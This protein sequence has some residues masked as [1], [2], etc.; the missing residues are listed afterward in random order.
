MSKDETSDHEKNID[1]WLDQNGATPMSEELAQFLANESKDESEEALKQRIHTA[2]YIAHQADVMNDDEV[3][4]WNRG[5]AFEQDKKP[6]WQWQGLPVLSTGFSIFALLLVVFNVEFVVQ[7]EGVLLSFGG[8]S[9]AQ[10]EAKVAALVDLR[11]KEFASEQQV[12]LANYTSDIKVK[13]QESNLQLASYIFSTARQERTEDMNELI[14]YLVEQRKDEQ[15]DQKIRFS[16]L[17][18][19]INRATYSNDKNTKFQPANWAVEE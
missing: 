14:G 11:L 1:K 18:Q 17:E 10:Q 3:P 6:W 13:Q 4:N 5:A 12:V 9:N 2:N 19:K 16:Q 7:D 8:Q 15:L